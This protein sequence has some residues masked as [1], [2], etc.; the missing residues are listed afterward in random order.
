M[1]A[2]VEEAV[3]HES[4]GILK[5]SWFGERGGFYGKPGLVAKVELGLWVGT[6]PFSHLSSSSSIMPKIK[7]TRTKK[8]PEGFEEIEP[9]GMLYCFQCNPL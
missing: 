2:Q 6:W 8:A 9:V 5:C 3:L 1:N 7:T 4:E